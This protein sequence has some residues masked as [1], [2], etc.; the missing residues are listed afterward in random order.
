MI[1]ID[2]KT[3]DRIL[4]QLEAL[5]LKV[6][7]FTNR[8]YNRHLPKLATAIARLEGAQD[9]FDIINGNK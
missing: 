8:N 4:K 7:D 9:I 3:H 6:D 5:E 1:N 2:N